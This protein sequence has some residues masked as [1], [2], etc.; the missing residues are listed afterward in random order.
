[1]TTIPVSSPL[2]STVSGGKRTG[3]AGAMRHVART[4]Q[5]WRLR[6]DSRRALS[7]L[8]PHLLADIGLEHAAARR[9]TVKPFWLA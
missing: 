3:L 2:R 8:D 7:R 9:E 1:M 6:R 5:V 4:F